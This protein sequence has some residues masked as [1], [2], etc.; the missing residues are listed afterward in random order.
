MGL[1]QLAG[2]ERLLDRTERLWEEGRK[3]P[4]IYVLLDGW[5]ISQVSGRDRVV[6]IKVHLPGDVLGLPS[7]AY[8]TAAETAV[9]LTAARLRPLALHSFGQL[10]EAH[11][12]VAAIM[13][14]V[15]QQERM[16]LT[17]RL[18]AEH[19]ASVRQKLAQF[20]CRILERVRRSF[21]DTGN[22]FYL[23]LDRNHVAD[24]V[25]AKS[26]QLAKAI[27]ELRAANVVGWTS[28][29]VTIV[30]LDALRTEANLPDRELDRGA[31]WLPIVDSGKISWKSTE[32]I[33]RSVQ[34]HE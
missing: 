1:S 29:L 31:H 19:T 3:L 7:L 27:K 6:T 24:L 30:D 8:A 20:L 16:V 32:D 5:M 9:A 10:F 15:S 22:S 33:Q 13:F 26:A 11:P 28:G 18:V 12:R 34:S 2:E 23:P 17:D 25:G 4:A 21:P 14:M